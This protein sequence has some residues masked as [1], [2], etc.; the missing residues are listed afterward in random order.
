M[1]H[2][3]LPCWYELNASD[4]ARE[5]AFY[6]AIL[7]WTWRDAEMP[8]MTYMIA[9]TEGGMVAGL[10][11]AEAG[12][13]TGWTCYVAVDS[14]DETAAL[15]LSLGAHQIVPPSDIPGTGRFALL[16]DPQG[17]LFGLLQPLPGGTG[18][19]FDPAK[20]GHGG[21]NELVTTDSAAAMAFYGKLFGWTLSSSMEMGPDMTYHVFARAG[22]DIGGTFATPAGAP[23]WKPY[24]GVPSCAESVK[25]VEAAGG[26]V[27]HGPDAVPGGAIT[28]QITDPG[29]VF[30]AL[31]SP[32]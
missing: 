16:V 20:M 29:G 5:T 21:W 27:M 30:L 10:M 14:A 23:F 4:V 26:R 31:V 28:L 3:G 25:A 8:G 13:P 19:A 12:Q 1:T 22:V 11:L 9:S 7:P 32:A 24:F 18:G 15:A 2:Q 17:A 6:S